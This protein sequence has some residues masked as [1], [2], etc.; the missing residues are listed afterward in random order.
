MEVLAVVI[1]T[2]AAVWAFYV[3]RKVSSFN[4]MS[5]LDFS[6]WRTRFVYSEMPARSGMARAFLV[7]SLHLAIAQ[8]IIKKADAADVEADLQQADAALLVDTWLNTVLTDV[9]EVAGDASVARAEARMIGALMLLSL[10]SVNRQG[11]L[12]SYLNSR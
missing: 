6:T 3:S 4:K 1:C 5:S 9:I 8:G 2:L 10:Q 12:R 11:A 7:Q